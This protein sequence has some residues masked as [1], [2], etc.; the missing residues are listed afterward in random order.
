VARD[1]S[2][3]G[4]AAREAIRSLSSAG[5]RISTVV[6][7]I[8]D[9]ASQTNL[10]ALNAT[11]EA[12]R[13]GEAGKGFAVVAAEVKT[14]ATQTAHATAEITQQIGNLQVAT[15]AAVTQVEA[16]GQT[17]D[18]VAEVSVSV[19]A[20]IEQQT[21][22]TREIAHSA[23]E[24][25]EAMLRITGL[26]TEVSREANSTGEQAGQLLGNAGA[27]ADDVVSL[28]SSLVHTV[29]T[30][31]AE[32]DRLADAQVVVD[33]TCSLNLGGTTVLGRLRDLSTRGAT[34]EMAAVDG[35]A[36]GGSGQ[37]TLSNARNAQA[38]FE[39]R[40]VEAPRHLHVRFM[41]GT[42]APAFHAA[43]TRLM[44][45]ASPMPLRA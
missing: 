13:A 1:A 2:G 6:Q 17:L 34:I 43:I 20:A 5:E 19:A 32:A 31:T 44:E 39:V 36:A 8:A 37:I 25:G 7:L 23:A 9:I 33:V 42:V 38:R 14:L 12:A 29:R 41:A 18:T 35:I 21:A 22:A 30:A 10:L 16:V 45:T 15:L 3:K 27:V 24:S 40:S 4:A 26:M 28:R 11:I